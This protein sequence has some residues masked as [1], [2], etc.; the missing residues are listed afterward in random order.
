[1]KISYKHLPA[2][3][4]IM[5]RLSQKLWETKKKQADRKGR[6]KMDLQ[7][8]KCVMIL[9]ERLPVGLIANT[10][11]ILGI[12][13][14]KMRPEAVGADVTDKTG[15]IHPGIIEFPVPILKGDGDCIRNLRET[16]YQ[17]E[18]SDLTAIDFSD[19]AQGCRTYPE[20][21][22]KMSGAEETDLAYLGIAICGPK[23]KVSRL[24]GTLPLLR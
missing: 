20:F 12:T 23:K 22:Q 1:M 14:G 13:L 10:A 5:T 19:L 17:P 6:M 7:K 8:E 16:L 3:R 15:N 2:W 18:F 21:I 9:D 4:V 11:A 24:T